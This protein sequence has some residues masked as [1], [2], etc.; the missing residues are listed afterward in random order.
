[1]SSRKGTEKEIG[2]YGDFGETEKGPGALQP[3]R[4][5]WPLG[6]TP[7]GGLSMDEDSC[8]ARVRA[9]FCGEPSAPLIGQARARGL[10]A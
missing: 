5:S 1:M 4:P 8:G 7:G 9:G 2:A 3:Q 6:R 10:G